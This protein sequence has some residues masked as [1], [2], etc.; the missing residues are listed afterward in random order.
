MVSK[1]ARCVLGLGVGVVCSVAARGAGAQETEAAE[2]SSSAAEARLPAESLDRAR[3][4]FQFSLQGSLLDYHHETLRFDAPSSSSTGPQEVK[5]ST[6]G[7]GFLG[8]SLGAGIGYAWDQLL[9]GPRAELSTTN[10]T[11][12]PP[13][14]TEQESS[15]TT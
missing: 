13:T 12:S 5:T 7:V 11:L 8:S 4:A 14:G 1:V 3:D 2:A 6:T 15:S 10:T 9:L